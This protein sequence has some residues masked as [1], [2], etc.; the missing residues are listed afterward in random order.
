MSNP[1]PWTGATLRVTRGWGGV[2]AC[3][4]ASFPRWGGAG[5]RKLLSIKCFPFL[6]FVS[7]LVGVVLRANHFTLLRANHFRLLYAE[8]SVTGTVRRMSEGGMRSK[9][10]AGVNTYLQRW[11]DGT[12][13]GARGGKRSAAAAASAGGGGGGSASTPG[14]GGAGTPQTESRQRR[15]EEMFFKRP[16]AGGGD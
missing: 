12:G 4:T 8:V 5:T 3:T 9:F 16:K 1:T 15:L 6:F 2:G 11:G 14:G 13:G 7:S 10:N